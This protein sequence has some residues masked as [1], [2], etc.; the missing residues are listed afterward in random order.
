M[1]HTIVWQGFLPAISPIMK[2]RHSTLAMI[3]FRRAPLSTFPK[4]VS[5]WQWFPAQVQQRTGNDNNN[6]NNNNN[7]NNNILKKYLVCIFH[8][9]LPQVLWMLVYSSWPSSQDSLGVWWPPCQTTLKLRATTR[10]SSRCQIHMWC[11][12]CTQQYAV[13]IQSCLPI[14]EI[15]LWH[16]F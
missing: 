13:S 9:E 8:Q 11:L 5:S 7:N 16:I 1:Q 15:A 10:C 3:S 14:N 12:P 2:R 4:S 6:I